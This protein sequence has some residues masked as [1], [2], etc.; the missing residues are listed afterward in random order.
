MRHA[1]E[2]STFLTLDESNATLAFDC[3]QTLRTVG[4]VTRKNHSHGQPPLLLRQRPEKT[5]DRQMKGVI[6]WSGSQVQHAPSDGESGVRRNDIDKIRL[7]DHAV[8]YLLNRH[9]G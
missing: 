3:L 9:R 8:L 7:D 6:R 5:V 1:A 4:T 2:F